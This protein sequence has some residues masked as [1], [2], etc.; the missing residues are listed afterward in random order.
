M[1]ALVSTDNEICFV[2][3]P[4]WGLRRYNPFLLSLISTR[5]M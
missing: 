2:P 4:G 5:W 3:L 1:N